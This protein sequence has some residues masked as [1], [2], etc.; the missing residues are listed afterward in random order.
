MSRVRKM[1]GEE[2]LQLS[3]AVEEIIYRN[4]NNGYT[5]MT[6]LCDGANATAVGMMPNVNIGDELKLSGRWKT[7][8]SY[9]EQFAFE[10]YEQ[11]VPTTEDSIL[12]YLS[13]GACFWRKH[14]RSDTA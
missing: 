6:L 7:H 10:Y 13:S 5:V 14:T 8:A 3:G 2:L 4:E 11:Y 9:G 1:N 12:K